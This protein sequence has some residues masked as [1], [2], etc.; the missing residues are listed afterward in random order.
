MEKSVEKITELLQGLATQL[1]HTAA[2]LWPHVVLATW[3]EAVGYLLATLLVAICLLPV[4]YR[5][6]KKATSD[7]NEGLVVMDVVSGVIFGILGVA[8]LV[9]LLSNSGIWMRAIVSPTGAAVL[10]LLGK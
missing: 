3:A 10:N 9:T 4:A 6:V 8:A 7:I 1:G 5:F 2:Q